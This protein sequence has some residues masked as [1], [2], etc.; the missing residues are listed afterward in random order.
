LDSSVVVYTTVGCSDCEKVKEYLKSHGIEFE[1]RDLL[2]EPKYQKKVEEL[3]F[4]GIPVVVA[5]DFAFKGFDIEKLEKLV[6]LV[7]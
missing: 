3:G 1:S 4:M 5:G 6:S 7:K 2:A